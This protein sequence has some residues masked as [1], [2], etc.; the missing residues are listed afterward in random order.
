VERIKSGDGYFQNRKTGLCE[1]AGGFAL[2]TETY[3]NLFPH[4]REGVKW[5]WERHQA[6]IPG[7]LLGDDMGSLFFPHFLS[8]LDLFYPPLPPP[9]PLCIWLGCN[10]SL[11]KTV[12]IISFLRGLFF[13]DE[14]RHVLIVMPKVVLE[15]WSK[16]FSTWFV[17][18]M[19]SCLASTFDRLS[20]G[21]Y[22]YPEMRVKF[23][24]GNGTK[25][26]KD[27]EVIQNKGGVLLTTYGDFSDTSICLRK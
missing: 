22:R 25:K 11:G 15:N 23:F 20:H 9:P 6:L 12:Q 21:Q 17:S 13:S 3:F 7:A 5:L 18:L 8:F 24:H 26:F 27:L 16:E 14:V 2:P 1:L 19:P 4:Q 10:L